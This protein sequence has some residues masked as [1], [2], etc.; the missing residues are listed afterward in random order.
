MALRNEP[1]ILS[2]VI[3]FIAFIF[4]IF[5]C[6]GI[7]LFKGEIFPIIVAMFSLLFMCFFGFIPRVHR[8]DENHVKDDE[9]WNSN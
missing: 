1:E 7:V 9:Y 8:I 3:W 6:V 2:S 5:S 4:L